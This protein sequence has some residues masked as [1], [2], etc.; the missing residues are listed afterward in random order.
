M[1][2]TICYDW[3][4]QFTI[5]YVRWSASSNR[6]KIKQIVLW[7]FF[8]LVT[9]IKTKFFPILIDAILKIASIY[10]KACVVIEKC[11]VHRYK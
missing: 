10:E 7:F 8:L 5:S 4:T 6:R 11:F 3:N 1:E 2:Y 9:S